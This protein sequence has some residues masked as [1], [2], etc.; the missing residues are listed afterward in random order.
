MGEGSAP[1]GRPSRGLSC[2]ARL[3]LDSTVL[4]DAL[5]GRPATG[6]VASLR[7]AGVEPWVCAISVEE[8]WRGLRRREEAAASRLF[9]GLRLAPLGVTEGIR[10]GSWRRWHAERGVTLHQADCLIAAA[11]VNIGAALATANVADF[12]MDELV[13]EHWPIDG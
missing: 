8:I 9:R 6:R 3:L 2:V 4:I 1:H 11:A 13:V 12:P 5:R 10:A 7:R